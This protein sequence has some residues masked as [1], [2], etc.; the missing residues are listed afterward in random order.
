MTLDTDDKSDLLDAMLSLRSMTLRDAPIH[1]RIKS[2][3]ATT[4]VDTA[5]VLP[6]APPVPELAEEPIKKKKKK[7]KVRGRKKKDGR[8]PFNQKGGQS[9]SLPATKWASLPPPTLGE[10]NFPTLQDKKVEWETT[11]VLAETGH[12]RRGSSTSSDDDE[13]EDYEERNSKA[14]DLEDEK[15][16]H[17][18]KSLKAMSDGASTATTTSSSLDFLPKK[19]LPA[20]GYVAALMGASKTF[21]SSTATGFVASSNSARPSTAS[22]GSKVVSK[23]M[24]QPMATTLAP[25]SDV[26]GGRRSF[27]DV[28][29]IP[30]ETRTTSS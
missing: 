20:G 11:P 9:G 5:P 25:K 13:D 1:A 10:D 2:T 14:D 22:S 23:E 27:A 19:I 30:Q 26:W 6:W 4:L 29:F 28:V 12:S 7:K 16:E 18:L 21:P 17:E 3:A 24:K 15:G 8:V